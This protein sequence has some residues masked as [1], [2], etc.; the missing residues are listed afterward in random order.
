MPQ[1][2]SLRPLDEARSDDV[3]WPNGPQDDNDNVR[4]LRLNPNI[5]DLWDGPASSEV[6]ALEMSKA[7]RTGKKPDLGEN[8]KVSIDM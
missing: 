8:R 2:A 6:A 5:A 4:V 7:R 1:D 3:W